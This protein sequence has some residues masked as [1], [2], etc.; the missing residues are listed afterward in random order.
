MI[1]TKFN[2]NRMIFTRVIV[3]TEFKA[4][5]NEFERMVLGL[6]RILK[7][8]SKYVLG[9]TP[10]VM[11]IFALWRNSVKPHILLAEIKYRVHCIKITCIPPITQFKEL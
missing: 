1:F 6:L 8:T 4:E 3:V 7:Q 9:L 2:H 10:T 11:L 5:L